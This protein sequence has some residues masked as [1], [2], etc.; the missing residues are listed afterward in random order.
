MLEDLFP[1]D[2]EVVGQKPNYNGF[3]FFFLTS[4]VTAIKFL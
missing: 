1:K 2:M 3:F 4:K